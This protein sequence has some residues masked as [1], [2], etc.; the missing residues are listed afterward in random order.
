MPITVDLEWTD[1]CGGSA[2]GL[3]AYFGVFRRELDLH[4]LALLYAHENTRT[5]DDA[6][7]LEQS[8]RRKR[9]R[10]FGAG[11]VDPVP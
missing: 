8:G 6:M 9:R 7:P 11:P 1:N 2:R 4:D 3:K 5:D 10:G